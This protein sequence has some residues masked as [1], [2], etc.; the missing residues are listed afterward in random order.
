[1]NAVGRR[2]V[3][4]SWRVLIDAIEGTLQ[5]HGIRQA[6]L[7]DLGAALDEGASLLPIR[8]LVSARTRQ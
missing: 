4:G 6:G 7:D 8:L 2:I 3:T 5:G 1:M